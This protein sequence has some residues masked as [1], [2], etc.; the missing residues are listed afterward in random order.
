MNG[1]VRSMHM[2]GSESGRGLCQGML[3][4][5]QGFLKERCYNQERLILVG[6][7]NIEVVFRKTIEESRMALIPYITAGDPGLSQTERLVLTFAENGA[8]IVELGVPFSDPLA[9][10]PTIQRASERSLK[11]GTTLRR[12]LA[13]VEKIREKSGVPII[14]MS[15]YNPILKMGLNAFAKRAVTAGVDGVIIPDLPPEEAGGWIKSARSAKLATIFLIAPT[16]TEER[17]Q[18]IA[19]VSRG[20]IYYVSLTGV[21]GVRK[22]LQQDVRQRLN[23]IRRFTKLPLCVGFGISKPEHVRQL[24]KG[25][26]GVIVGSALVNL[27]EQSRSMDLHI[28]VG[29]FIQSLKKET[30]R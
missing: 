12:I 18:K 13:V 2:A 1:L 11:K 9:D 10:G 8:D 4:M 6:Q 27:I 21:T 20:F 30:W 14:L 24:A 19:R 3:L 17:I 5:W 25:A 28:N 22:N 26:G 23:L 15:Y 29:R 16:S 7:K